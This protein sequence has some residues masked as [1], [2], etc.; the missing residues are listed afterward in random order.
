MCMGRIEKPWGYEEHI[1]TTQV[2]IGGERGMLGIR[3][4]VINS[5]EMTS[6]ARHENQVD[7]I[8]LEEGSAILRI[9][10]DLEE[11]KKGKASIIRSGEKHQLQNI[12]SEVAEVLEI[13]FPYRP[14]DIERI[15]DPYSKRR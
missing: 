15:E 6:Y 7:I 1:L 5:D 8:Y 3:K 12:D 10:E 4:L 2:E 14:D 13:S 11:L 9:E